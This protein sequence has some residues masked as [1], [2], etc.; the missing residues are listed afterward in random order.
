MSAPSDE[1]VELALTQADPEE[2]LLTTDKA[3]GWQACE[4]IQRLR[5]LF[6]YIKSNDR[7]HREFKRETKD[8]AA[9]VNNDTR[10]NSWYHMLQRG[11]QTRHALLVIIEVDEQA[12]QFRLT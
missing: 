4:A 11:R 10:W 3:H 8:L 2:A 5:D 1:A 9:I 12:Y 7:C 6:A